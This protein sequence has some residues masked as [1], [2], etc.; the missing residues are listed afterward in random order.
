MPEIGFA[1]AV[2]VAAAVVGIIAYNLVF[3]RTYDE[4]WAWLHQRHRVTGEVRHIQKVRGVPMV[5]P[6]PPPG[7]TRPPRPKC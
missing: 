3:W 2:S 6:P 5:P 1:L 4:T 7:S